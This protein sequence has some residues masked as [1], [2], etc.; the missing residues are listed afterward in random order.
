MSHLVSNQVAKGWFC[1]QLFQPQVK[2][3]ALGWTTLLPHS[4]KNR[5]LHRSCCGHF[6]QGHGGLELILRRRTEGHASDIDLTCSRLIVAHL[7]TRRTTHKGALSDAPS[8]RLTVSTFYQHG[9]TRLLE[10][11]SL[12][13]Y[14]DVQIGDTF[15]QNAGDYNLELA[16]YQVSF[17][18]HFAQTY[19][20]YRYSH[21]GMH[22]VQS[23][24][25]GKSCLC[26]QA[27]TAVTFNT[28]NV[29][30][31]NCHSCV[32]GFYVDL[33]P[34]WEIP[35][36]KQTQQVHAYTMHS[37]SHLKSNKRWL[38]VSIYY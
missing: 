33:F 9:G 3:D 21:L 7:P 8:Y 13:L 16:E 29:F 37:R 20:I 32:R 28:D 1:S 23:V 5:G 6:S 36:T 38:I 12:D 17:V 25:P 24:K 22:Y 14:L 26:E 34:Q 27:S 30:S 11:L 35:I 31:C 4:A 19:R 10:V 18:L 2:Q 15:S